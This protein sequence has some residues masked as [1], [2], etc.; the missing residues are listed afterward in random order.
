MNLLPIQF[1]YIRLRRL[2]WRTNGEIGYDRYWQKHNNNLMSKVLIQ[3]NTFYPDDNGRA[4]RLASRIRHFPEKGWT[5]VVSVY[6]EGNTQQT[7]EIE[8]DT[9]QVF[10]DEDRY[11]NDFRGDVRGIRYIVKKLVK[12]ISFPD[13]YMPLIIRGVKDGYKLVR[14]ENIDVLYTISYPFTGHLIGLILSEITDVSWLAEF[15]DP[16]VTNPILNDS[17]KMPHQVLEEKVVYNSDKI[18]YNYGI[19]VP[20]NYF[21]EY[22]G[23]PNEKILCLNCPG[24]TGFDFNRFNEIQPAFNESRF[25]IVYAGSFYGGQHTPEQFLESVANFV[26]KLGL[27]QQDIMVHFFG[28]WSDEYSDMAKSLNIDELLQIHGWVPFETVFSY[29]LAGDASLLITL[30]GDKLNIP[31]K[32]IDYISAKSPILTITEEGSRT[33][34]YIKKHKIGIVS[35]IGATTET[36]RAI[37]RL[38]RAKQNG[39]LSSYQPSQELLEQIDARTLSARFSTALDDLTD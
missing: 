10:R 3:T 37:E 38:Y 7:V 6:P 15:Q 4:E 26:D 22:Y 11:I 34:N 35:S 36:T 14:E 17:W 39:T 27:T 5:P 8:G 21:K 33:E 24:S 19:Q 2:Y 29:L 12:S 23:I 32:P 31:S 20:D 16:W 25:T 28:D 9:I 18:V 1:M 13:T 30:P